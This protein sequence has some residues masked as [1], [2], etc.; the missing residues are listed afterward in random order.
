M[1]YRK[2]PPFEVSNR[3]DIAIYLHW[4][5]LRTKVTILIH[6]DWLIDQLNRALLASRS[7]SPPGTLIL[8]FASRS[9]K[10]VKHM[11]EDTAA[12][13]AIPPQIF[14]PLL[15][16]HCLNAQAAQ[17]LERDED[18]RARQYR[19]DQIYYIGSFAISWRNIPISISL[20]AH[21]FC[22]GRESITKMLTHG[23]E[24]PETC[25]RHLALNEDGE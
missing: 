6:S 19:C 2:L 12:T 13:Q 7:D 20:L 18:F 15:I 24:P 14:L 23:L 21:A 5:K 16:Q 1:D 3:R 9:S 10:Y 11:S 17:F 22:Y 8:S 25:I 4:V